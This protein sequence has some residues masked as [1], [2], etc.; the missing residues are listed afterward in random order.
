MK[1][2]LYLGALLICTSAIAQEKPKE[3]KEETEV[4]IVKVKDNDKTTEKKV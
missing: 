3:V 4:K 1:N 2:L